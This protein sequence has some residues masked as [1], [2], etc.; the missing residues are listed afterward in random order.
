[1]KG[2]PQYGTQV[3]TKEEKETDKITQQMGRW[4]EKEKIGRKD[5]RKRRQ[6][7]K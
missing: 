3:D 4:T 7:R 6:R 5:K 1:M 2:N